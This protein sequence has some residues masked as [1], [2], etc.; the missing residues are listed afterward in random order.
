MENNRIGKTRDLVKKRGDIKGTF[1]ERMGMIKDK[2]SKDL[3]E[4][5]ESKSKWQQYTEERHKK[6]LNDPHNH[7]GVVTHLELDILQCEVKR[8]LGSITMNKTSRADG[9]SAELFKILKNNAVKCCTQYV[10]KIRKLSSGHRTG[11]GH[12]SFQSQR[13]GN[14][15]ECSNYSTTALIS[16]ANKVTLKI[17]QVRLQQ[18]MN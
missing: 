2:N 1:H 12:Y 3:T 8:V 10:N 15:K 13:K 16:Q 4:T 6:V 11:K 5:E 9:I 17:L 18:Y 7:D 14:A